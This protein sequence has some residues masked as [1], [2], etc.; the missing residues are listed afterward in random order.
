MRIYLVTSQAVE[1]DKFGVIQR[2]DVRSLGA[3]TMRSR[4]DDIAAK[5]NGTVREIVV[6]S[7]EPLGLQH[8]LNPGYVREA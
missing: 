1:Q 5:Y 2:V 8:W 6:D 3:F 7:D 4:A